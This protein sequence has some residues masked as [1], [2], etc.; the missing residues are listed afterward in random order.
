MSLPGALDSWSSARPLNR[1][2]WEFVEIGAGAIRLE[3]RLLKI[4]IPRAE[5]LKLA[6]LN[7]LTSHPA[8]RAIY[9]EL[10]LGNLNAH[11]GIVLAPDVTA[12][13]EVTRGPGMTRE[14]WLSSDEF[15][16]TLVEHFRGAAAKAVSD[17]HA[18]GLPV[19]AADV[20]GMI[21]EIPPPHDAST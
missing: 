20:H 3:E 8:W 17:H 15:K 6:G 14:E 18:R 19:H 12:A 16:R 5:E 7:A 1:S 21:V 9:E 4:T 2:P 13:T 11:T 10:R